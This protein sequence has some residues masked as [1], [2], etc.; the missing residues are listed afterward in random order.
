MIYILDEPSIGLHLRDNARL[1]ETLKKLRDLGN[2]VIVVEHD[3]GTIRA[4]DHIVDIGPGAGAHGGEIVAQGTLPEITATPGSIT[5]DYL[6]GRQSISVPAE[7]RLPGER[8][9]R[10]RGARE[11]NL[12]DI[13][14][15]IPLGLFVC[16]SGV[17]GSGKSTLV[18][19]ILARA[20]GRLLHRS[21]EPAG[22]HRAI[23]GVEHLDKVIV[24]DQSPIGRTPR[25]NPA[26]YTGLFGD[27]RELFAQTPEARRRGYRPGRFSFNV[28]GGR[29]EAC[30]G[31]GILR[32]EMHFLP[33]VY[34]VSYTHLDVYKRQ[35]GG[36]AWVNLMS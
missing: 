3:E 2:T 20:L 8:S 28:K 11:H 7:R 26:T 30:R 24:V 31:D 21:R 15:E 35:S 23:E 27:I 14:V 18:N 25:S 1:L 13:D 6:A 22:A 34:A 4:A 5:G 10:I 36:C 33:D 12:K 16:V 17:S 29:C 19:E 32:I 9:L